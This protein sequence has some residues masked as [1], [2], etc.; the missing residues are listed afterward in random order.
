MTEGTIKSLVG[1]GVVLGYLGI[2]V[3]TIILYFF[4]GFLFDELTTI[5]ALIVPMFGIYCSAIIKYITTNR[6]AKRKK[7]IE[8]TR[9][10][11]L[12]S[13]I[14]P[15]VFIFSL[16]VIIV[17][18]ACNLAFSNFDQF[19]MTLGLLQTAFGVYMGLILAEMFEIKKSSEK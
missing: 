18:K 4:G 8:I 19:K 12:I 9:V 3:L 1:V 11:A 6:G 2:V 5:I 10:Y 16:G 15:S 13:V 14:F 17:L 7:T